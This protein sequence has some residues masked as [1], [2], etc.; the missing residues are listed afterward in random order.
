MDTNCQGI[1]FNLVNRKLLNVSL[2]E[3]TE[4]MI[5][6]KAEFIL[7]FCFIIYLEKY[8][9]NGRDDS[10]FQYVNSLIDYF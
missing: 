8:P 9:E 4:L 3:K 5:S 6:Y 1:L 2:R 7:G 10:F